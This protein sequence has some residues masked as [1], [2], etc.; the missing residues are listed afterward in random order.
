MLSVKIE[1]EVLC[2]LRMVMLLMTVGDLNHPKRGIV[3]SYDLF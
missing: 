3:M 1:Q 2:T